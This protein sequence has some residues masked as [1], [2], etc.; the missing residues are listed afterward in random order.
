M[1]QDYRSENNKMAGL[2]V[3]K[4]VDPGW[5]RVCDTSSSEYTKHSDQFLNKIKCC[6]SQ[7][8]LT[9]DSNSV[10]TY[11]GC[12]CCIAAVVMQ[13]AWND[14][15]IAIAIAIGLVIKSSKLREMTYA[16]HL[17]QLLYWITLSLWLA[18]IYVIEMRST[19][20]RDNNHENDDTVITTIKPVISNSNIS[21]AVSIFVITGLIDQLSEIIRWC[22]W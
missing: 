19:C 22:W 4:L 17:S 10:S 11:F 3:L 6:T 12:N 7:P 1:L 21:M 8:I 20:I 2:G 14:I 18:C 9:Y 5:S 16:S 13:N 15:S